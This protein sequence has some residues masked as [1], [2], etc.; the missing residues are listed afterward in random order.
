MKKRVKTEELL[1]K[2]IVYSIDES[3]PE[4]Q[5]IVIYCEE[6][7]RLYVPKSFIPRRAFKLAEYEQADMVKCKGKVYVDT[8]WVMAFLE[9][10]GTEE[11]VRDLF[12]FEQSIK[13]KAK[14]KIVV[15]IQ[16]CAEA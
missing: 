6:E 13:K 8:R 12:K 5:R 10:Y 3:I 9:E 15:Y 14:E 1:F 16:K 7:D 11:D 4:W 2:V